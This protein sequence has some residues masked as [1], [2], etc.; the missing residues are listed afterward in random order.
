MDAAAAKEKFDAGA[1]LVQIYTGFVYR[2][3]HLIREIAA[4]SLTTSLFHV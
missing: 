2:G 1:S 4:L 3:P